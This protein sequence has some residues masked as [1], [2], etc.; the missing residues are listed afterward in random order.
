MNG[1]ARE[2]TEICVQA[3]KK[4]GPCDLFGLAIDEL[5]KQINISR[6]LQLSMLINICPKPILFWF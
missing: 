3:F 2:F 5:L 1:Y 4:T 6:Y